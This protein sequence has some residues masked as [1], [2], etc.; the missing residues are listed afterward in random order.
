[1]K[2]FIELI[3]GYKTKNKCL[4]SIDNIDSVFEHKD[5]KT[6]HHDKEYIIETNCWIELKRPIGYDQKYILT[7]E[8]YEEIKQKIKEAQG[9][10]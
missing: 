6:L 8:T 3:L 9:E 2:G 5:R 10:K 7:V 1:M 4:I